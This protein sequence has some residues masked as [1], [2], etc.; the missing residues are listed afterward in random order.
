V[1][2][3]W[4]QRQDEHNMMEAYSEMEASPTQIPGL[5]HLQIEAQDAYR[6]RF[7]TLSI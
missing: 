7:L 3:V 2:K 6:L 1:D 4:D 5:V